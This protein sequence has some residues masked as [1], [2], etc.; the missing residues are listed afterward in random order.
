VT[1]GWAAPRR[2]ARSRLGSREH[3]YASPHRARCES[4]ASRQVEGARLRAAVGVR[5]QRAAPAKVVELATTPDGAADL[6]ARATYDPAT[7]RAVLVFENFKAP[8]GSATTSCGRSAATPAPA[9]L[10]LISRRVGP[11][12]PAP[13]K[14]PAIPRRW[15]RSP[16]RS[17]RPAAPAIPQHPPGR[18]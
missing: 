5:A 12:D 11:R 13:R 8:S 9:S 17:R 18:S 16:S 2:R 1:W 6:K 4:P 10:G 3:G 15:A 7:Q 14:R